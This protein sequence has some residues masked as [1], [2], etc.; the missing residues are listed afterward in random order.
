M[1]VLVAPIQ[2]AGFFS[3]VSRHSLGDNSP[4]LSIPVTTISSSKTPTPRTSSGSGSGRR[5][6][7]RVRPAVFVDLLQDY[8]EAVSIARD[9]ERLWSSMETLVA[10]VRAGLA[11]FAPE[12]ID[13]GEGGTYFLRDTE[14]DLLA[15]FKPSDEEPFA[16]GNPKMSKLGAGAPQFSS[17]NPEIKKGIRP[18][19]A[20]VR[21]LAAFLLDHGRA[22]VP[23]TAMVEL[24]HPALKGAK[25]GSLQQYV[26]HECG[27]W[28]LG[29]SQYDTRDA[30]LIGLLDIR[31]FNVDRH[32]GNILVQRRTAPS[33]APSASRSKYHLVPIDHGFSMPDSSNGLDLWFEWMTWPQSKV[34]F[35][36]ELTNFV[37]SINVEQD[38]RLLFALGLRDDCVRTMMMSSLLLKKAVLRKLTLHEIGSM[39]CRRDV[40]RP[41][42]LEQISQR[43]LVREP[44]SRYF[45][46]GLEQATDEVL[47]KPRRDRKHRPSYH[48]H[49]R[50]ISTTSGFSTSTTMLT[51]EPSYTQPSMLRRTSSALPFPSSQVTDP[52]L[53]QCPSFLLD[54][55]RRNLSQESL[56]TVSATS[57][58]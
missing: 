47:D 14:G 53:S 45:L 10:R 55:M 29:P 54:G 56:Q 28:D 18:G 19:E 17:N 52:F 15:V 22:G 23:L 44:R 20:A 1:N 57:I 58:C 2:P 34:A 9:G 35:D 8:K 11:Q 42:L 40:D 46:S 3:G 5:L 38:A 24:G 6:A 49:V 36:E 37:A 7:L 21:E 51:T 48:K 41:S 43:L 30:H 31:I 26:P 39:L 25:V 32:G 16:Q 13:E 27:S 50:N 4:I 12:L 33:S